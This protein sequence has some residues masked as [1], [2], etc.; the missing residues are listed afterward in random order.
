MRNKLRNPKFLTEQVC[1]N[2]KLFYP[3][4]PT[5][6]QIAVIDPGTTSCGV[7]IVR[8]YIETHVMNVIWFSVIDFG[9]EIALINTLMETSFGQVLPYL[10]DCHHIVIEHQLMKS[11]ITYQ[12]HAVTIYYISKYIHSQKMRPTLIEVDCQLKTTFLG[13]PKTRL[14]N[15]TD[16]MK[17]WVYNK[18][19]SWPE[20]G[21][22]E[23]K[24]WTKMKSRQFSSERDDRI[25][26]H[27]LENSLYKPNEDLS[28]TLCY[29]Y[30]WI[31]YCMSRNDIIFPFP[32][33]MLM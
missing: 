22:V 16:E 33:E 31:P 9:N 26:Y 15:N 30:A 7:R 5:F 21:T 2:S 14:V 29:E 1:L 3:D 20:N 25:S 8:Y 12:C 27:I 6:L 32:R 17:Q 28:D 10:I 19:G 4:L 11:E 13:G 24:E 18:T 23:I